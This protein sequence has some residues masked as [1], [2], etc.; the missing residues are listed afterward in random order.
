MRTALLLTVLGVLAISAPAAAMETLQARID[1]APPG[2]EI[3]VAGVASGPVVIRKPLRIVGA[4]GAAIDGGGQGTIV[5]IEAPGVILSRLTL[6][7]SGRDLNTEDAGVFV[8]APGVVLEDLAL[9]EVLFGVNLKQAHG[10]VIRRLAVRGYDLPLSRRGDGVRL[11]YSYGVTLSELRLERVRDLLLWF[12]RGTTL[13]AADVRR[14]RYGVHLMYADATRLLDGS[15]EDNAVGAYIMYSTGV[16]VEGNRFLRHRG[17]TGVGLALK[18]SD[19]VLIRSNLL[20]GNHVGLYVDGTPRLLAAR[21][22]IIDNVI[23]GNEIGL[24]LLGSAGGNVIAGNVLDG[25]ILQVRIDGGRRGGHRWSRGG[26]GNYWS[27]YAGLDLRRDGVGDTP[28]RARQWFES[29][30]DRIPELAWLRGS[31][32]A[33]AVDFAARAL[34]IFAPEVLLEDPRPLMRPKVPEAFRGAGA[35]LPFAVVSLALTAVGLALMGAARSSSRR[36]AV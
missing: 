10:A 31:I 32:A 24:Q 34:P 21:S 11:W 5:R 12:A 1:R 27:D 17:S 8:G 30:S 7:R 18:E 28:Y 29:L 36:S 6:R 2:S 20:A 35:S 14:S 3:V 23:A 33:A 22:E 19:D 9:E 15:F 13:H 4:P 26:R 25:N 16:R